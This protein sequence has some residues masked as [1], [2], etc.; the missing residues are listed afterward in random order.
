[1]GFDPPQGGGGGGGVS[2]LTDLSDVTAK[3]GSGTTVLMQGSPSITTP[4]I[5]SFA[6]SA[7]THQN[8]AGGAKLDH[9]AALNGLTDDDH[10]I[11]ALLAGRSGG[12][13]LR[14]GTDDGDDL[15]LAA[16]TNANGGTIFFQLASGTSVAEISAGPILYMNETANA[17]QTL[18][19]TINQGANDDEV[20][21]FKSSDVAHGITTQTETDT[22]AFMRK[23]AGANGGLYLVGVA[24][25]STAGALSLYGWVTADVST[26]KTNVA[27]AI[28]ELSAAKKS[29]T[30]VAAAG[31]NSNL[32]TIITG[33]AGFCRH[34]FDQDGDY[35]YDG[36][37]TDASDQAFDDHDDVGLLEG[38]RGLTGPKN[39]YLA[40]RFKEWAQR[41]RGALVEAGVV[42]PS[43]DGTFMVSN[44]RLSWLL[45]DAMRQVAG[46]MERLEEDKRRLGQRVKALEA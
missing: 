20:L 30:T 32:L 1:M 15:T 35:H 12:Q 2:Q 17:K 5:A 9:G 24:D 19:I 29:G 45:I 39:G 27:R 23:T 34:I 26:A 8:A 10:S 36:T 18:G 37:V 40:T 3:S 21:T 44:K 6:N 22:F 38:V 42:S 46:R 28:I 43:P 41:A 16:T 11:Y 13:I 31:A 25:S 14:G 4:T 33:G 7:H